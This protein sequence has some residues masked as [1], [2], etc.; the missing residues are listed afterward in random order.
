M[1]KKQE[2]WNDEIRRKLNRD[3]YINISNLNTG[4]KFD[5]FIE[6]ESKSDIKRTQKFLEKKGKKVCT[7]VKKLMNCKISTDA[8]DFNNLVFLNFELKKGK[9]K[10]L[11][12]ADKIAEIFNKEEIDDDYQYVV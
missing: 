8:D 4:V 6:V 1:D 5:K 9:K 10:S 11:P 3:E 2:Q 12:S 7:S